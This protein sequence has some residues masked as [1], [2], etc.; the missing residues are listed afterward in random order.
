MIEYNCRMGDPETEVVIPRIQNDLVELLV[1]TAAGDL[2][3]QTIETDSRYATTIV[4]VSG[5]YPEDFQKGFE[6]S[7]LENYFTDGII[8]HAGTKA[9]NGKIVTNGGRVLCATAL[10]NELK[11]AIGKSRKMLDAISFEGK[12]FRSDIGYEFGPGNS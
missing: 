11:E 6:I 7:G 9:D 12:Y 10:A 1:A 5:G 3:A 4:A 2:A 8:F